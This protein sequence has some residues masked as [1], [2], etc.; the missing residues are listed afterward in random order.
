[1][2][3]MM[4]LQHRGEK[5]TCLRGDMMMESHLSFWVAERN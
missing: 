1:M 5:Q 4:C 2:Q 3:K